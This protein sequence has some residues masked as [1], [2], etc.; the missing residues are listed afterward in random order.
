M[1]D[2]FFLEPDEAKS[3]GDIDYMRK[4]RK[5]KKSFPSSKAW[6]AG[7]EVEEEIS[8]TEKNGFKPQPLSSNASSSFSSVSSAAS[9]VKS[10]TVQRRKADNNMDMFRSMAKDIRK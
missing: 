5:V 7:F 6:G 1:A 3:M 2:A 10:E 8:A 4:A 9:E